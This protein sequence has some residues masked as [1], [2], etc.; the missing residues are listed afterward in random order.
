VIFLAGTDLHLASK[1][2]AG[3]IDADFPEETFE[4]L[5]QLGDVARQ[6]QARA[7]LW[8]GDLFHDTGRSRPR[9]ADAGA[10]G[11]LAVDAEGGSDRHRRYSRQ[12]RPQVQSL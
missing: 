4:L 2:P 8:P 3:R 1:P 10:H 9:L 5:T 7:I 12:P 6:V 11:E